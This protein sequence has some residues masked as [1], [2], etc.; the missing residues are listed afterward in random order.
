MDNIALKRCP[1]RHRWDSFR[2]MANLTAHN[3]VDD[4]LELLRSGPHT[5]DEIAIVLGLDPAGASRAV[6]IL[7]AR[8]LVRQIGKDA[9][10]RPRWALNVSRGTRE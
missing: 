7:T 2:A 1:K 6:G 10:G 4:V 8:A 5:S 3:S 9:K